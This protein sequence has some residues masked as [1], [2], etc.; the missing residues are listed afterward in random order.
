M[1]PETSADNCGCRDG[2]THHSTYST[3]T[4]NTADLGRCPSTHTTA[5]TRTSPTTA[6]SPSDG[7]I[8]ACKV[9]F[10]LPNSTLCTVI[11]IHT[12]Q[13]QSQLCRRP[14]T[15]FPNRPRRLCR[16]GPLGKCTHQQKEVFGAN[17]I[18]MNWTMMRCA[19]NLPLG[20]Q[21]D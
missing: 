11:N 2:A 10:S 13:R 16:P 6:F 9:Q 4:M 3:S 1:K 8:A 15:K 20:D 18:T 7:A 12:N 21:T 14:R 5:S 19:E 17:G